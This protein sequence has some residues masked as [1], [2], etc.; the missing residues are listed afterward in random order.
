MFAVAPVTVQARSGGVCTGTVGPT[1]PA[2][3]T[4]SAAPPR[5]GHRFGGHLFSKPRVL[6]ACAKAG[7]QSRGG[8]WLAGEGWRDALAGLPPFPERCADLAWGPPH[9]TPCFVFRRC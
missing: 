5:P 9:R 8:F 3:L 1:L 6:R 2:V 4:P 7:G